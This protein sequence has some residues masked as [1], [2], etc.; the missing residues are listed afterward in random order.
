MIGGIGGQVA[1]TAPIA[2][3]T[4][5]GN[6]A[7][8]GALGGVM[9]PVLEGESTLGNMAAGAA[10]GGVGY[11]IPKVLGAMAQPIRQSAPVKALLDEGI[12]PTIGQAARSTKSFAGKLMGDI[13]DAATSIPG[14]GGII[15]GARGRAGEELQRTAIARATPRGVE[16]TKLLGREGIEETASAVSDAYRVALDKIGTVRLDNQFLN[17]APQIVQRAVALNPQ[18]KADVA[19]V[20]EQ[21]ISSRMNP[22]Q[23]V[24]TADIAK[25][26]DSD[27]G[28]YVREYSRSSQ[29]SERQIASV[30]REVQSQWRDLI[31]R[32]APDTATA[33]ML[34]DANRAFANL[35]RVEKASIKSGSQGGEFTP[36][37]LNQAVKEM[38]P[39]K[40]QF[41]KGASMMQDLSDPAAQV[42]TGRL[43][44][45]GTVPRGIIGMGLLGGG[46]AY[47]NEQAGG[48]NWLT[49]LALASAAIA[50]LYSRAGS[51]YAVG[52]LIP[53]LQQPLSSVLNQAAPY[54]GQLGRA[55]GNQK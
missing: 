20:V 21:V 31:R 6:I 54:G 22:A 14:I 53:G 40:R 39:N 2:P 19:N 35:L 9:E 55:Y 38:T 28:S 24:V 18:Q 37:Q 4:L 12:I 47:A 34:D 48:P 43:G 8:G 16:P 15:K 51:R 45:S 36:A 46:G 42:L 29:A 5:L 1:M 49:N 26:I 11:A 33:N 10:G 52:D 50:P 3:Q 13:E 30:V 32:N 23:G 44:E 25:T 7:A 27:L 41:A 17:S